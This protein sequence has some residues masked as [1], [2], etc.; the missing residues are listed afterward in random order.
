MRPDVAQQGD[1]AEAVQPVGIVDHQRDPVAEPQI[2]REG[3]GDAGD[4]GRDR[5]IRQHASRLVA[6]RGVADTRGAAPHQHHR[7]VAVALQQAQQHDGHQAAHVQAVGGGVESDI[8][9]DGAGIERVGQRLGIGA[10]VDE[11]AGL[12]FLEKRACHE[13]CG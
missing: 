8:G 10:L 5:P 13:A 4:V 1:V 12:G 9:G 2:R 3:A 7:A 6:A 11:A